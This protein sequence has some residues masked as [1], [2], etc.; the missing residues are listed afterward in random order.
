MGHS[1]RVTA[2]PAAGPIRQPKTSCLYFNRSYAEELCELAAEPPG[3]LRLMLLDFI[4]APSTLPASLFERYSYD[5]T[6]SIFFTPLQREVVLVVLL[7]RQLAATAYAAPPLV[8]NAHTHGTLLA[9]MPL[10][11]HQ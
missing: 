5:S 7:H 4:S 6:L 2:Q 9:L 10:F 3:L 1:E 8:G 11:N